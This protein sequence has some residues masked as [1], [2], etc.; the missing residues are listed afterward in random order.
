MELAC[1]DAVTQASGGYDEIMDGLWVPGRISLP[2]PSGRQSS[3]VLGRAGV[4]EQ[5]AIAPVG[6]QFSDLAT[7][8]YRN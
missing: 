8:A 2:A 1:I 7:P 4:K 3:F 6:R 5:E